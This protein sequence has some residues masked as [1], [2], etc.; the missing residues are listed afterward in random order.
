MRNFWL[1]DGDDLVLDPVKKKDIA[2]AEEKLG[3]ELPSLYKKLIKKQNGGYIKRTVFPIDFS[4]SSVEDYIEVDSIYGIGEEGIL[5]SPYLINE[6]ELPKDLVLL[7][8]DGHTWV[9]MDYR[10]KTKDPSIVYIDVEEEVEIQIASSFR[11]FIEGLQEED[12]IIGEEEI[13]ITDDMDIPVDEI[14]KEQA[15][16]IFKTSDDEDEISR[17]ITNIIIDEENDINWMLDQLT[18]LLDRDSREG[19][20]EVIA[21]YLL[22]HSYLRGKM[23]SNKYTLL[24]NKLKSL[25][26]TDLKYKLEM[27]EDSE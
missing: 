21:G 11:E 23:D 17:T 2:L 7:N 16:S 5:D 10:G 1:G 19:I 20:A 18:I 9:A 15:E 27:I 12:M 25:P 6:W 22:V 24:M 26:Y 4:T 3:V 13:E 14:T 8:G